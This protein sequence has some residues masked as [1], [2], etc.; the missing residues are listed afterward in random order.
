MVKEIKLFFNR[1]LEKSIK[2]KTISKE[3][4][5][6][7]I[8]RYISWAL[9]SG[10][11]LS[12]RDDNVL[13]FKMMVIISLIISS[14]L[15]TDLYIR[16]K[17]NQRMLKKII[18]IETVG[19]AGL[20]IPTGG[21]VSPFIWY[22][23]NPILVAICFLP[24]YFS[25]INLIFYILSGTMITYTLFNPQNSAIFEIFKNN[26]NLILVFML[27]LLLLQLFS[28]LAKELELAN[29]EKQKSIEYIM[30]LYE[31]VETF[32]NHKSKEKLLEILVDYTAKLTKSE[33]S[34][35]WMPHSS[36]KNELIISSNNMDKTDQ[37]ELI[38]EFK[39]NWFNKSTGKRIH[40]INLSSKE[41]YVLPMVFFS[42]YFG[43][44]AI[45]KNK[46]DSND[47]KELNIKFLK[48]I[49]ELSAVILERFNLEESEELLAVLEEQNR[50]A[51]EI[52]DNVSQRIF[53]IFYGVHGVIGRWDNITNAELKEYMI[54]IKT[55]SNIAGQELKN[56]IYK[57]SSKKKGEKYLQTST[58]SF[59]DSIAK[60]NG[61]TIE[62]SIHGNESMLSIKLMK[63]INRIIREACSNAVRHSGCQRVS[64]DLVIENDMVDL[65][66]EDNGIGFKVDAI[67]NENR[68]GLGIA[69]MKN[70]VNLYDGKIEI[71]SYDGK[72]TDISIAIPIN[73]L[74]E[75]V[76]GA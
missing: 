38:L 46:C 39:R 66:I 64:I 24:S 68:S 69:N 5:I 29:R 60:L 72:G 26:S 75:N 47:E 63:A 2:S 52:H 74:N 7:Y 61:I 58:K 37:R 11:Y 43:M 9:T 73:R 65:S 51:D 28:K 8:Y 3:I 17:E 13:F 56:S 50:I 20:L 14:K 42:T 41:Y 54:E 34:L 23:L 6:I 35:F 30:A 76:E 59:L 27:I 44:I 21:L 1:L 70:L 10:V 48:F 22:A 31:M 49:S 71:S 18:F 4:K 32:N 12:G 67:D 15:I 36:E 55:S 45:Q 33:G 62:F 19:I 25:W 40:T 57:L 53:S 16:M